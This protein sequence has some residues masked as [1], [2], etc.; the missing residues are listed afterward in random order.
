MITLFK[1]ANTVMLSSSFISDVDKTVT[2]T[3]KE[4]LLVSI[5]I[6]LDNLIFRDVERSTKFLN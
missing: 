5:I 2:F 6:L 1:S 4:H 3:N